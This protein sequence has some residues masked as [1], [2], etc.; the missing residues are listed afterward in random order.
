MGMGRSL[1]DGE[2]KERKKKR[3]KKEEEGRKLGSS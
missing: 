2:G 3:K 1:K